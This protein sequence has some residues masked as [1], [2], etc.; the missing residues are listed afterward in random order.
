MSLRFLIE[1]ESLS[2]DIH[3]EPSVVSFLQTNTN[4]KSTLPLRPQNFLTRS[5][6]Q[7]FILGSTGQGRRYITSTDRLGL[8]YSHPH[9]Q[10][11]LISG[12]QHNCRRTIAHLIWT[13]TRL[14][15][16]HAKA[17]NISSLH[18]RLHPAAANLF[19][20]SRLDVVSPFL[21]AGDE[22]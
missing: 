19:Q 1:T 3:R 4:L 13:C 6:W 14:L 9:W 15:W 5:Q 8:H 12:I 20:T 18:L 22:A 10:H 17:T 2:R 11:V 16:S 21:L 7:E